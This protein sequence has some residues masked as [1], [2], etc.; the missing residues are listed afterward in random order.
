MS[1]KLLDNGTIFTYHDDI[2]SSPDILDVNFE[3]LKAFIKTVAPK[4]I[5]RRYTQYRTKQR[6]TLMDAEQQLATIPKGDRN[7]TL[8]ELTGQL[9]NYHQADYLL[10]HWLPIADKCIPDEIGQNQRTIESAIE[11]Y[12]DCLQYRQKKQ[13]AGDLALQAMPAIKFKGKA[14]TTRRAVYKALITRSNQEV[15]T[16]SFVATYRQIKKLTGI[17]SN[18]GI[19]KALQYLCNLQVIQR[20]S[21]NNASTSY[22]R[23]PSK[24]QWNTQVLQQLIDSIESVSS[25][26]DKAEVGQKQHISLTTD[27][28]GYY[29]YHLSDFD[30]DD[31]NYYEQCLSEPSALGRNGAAIYLYLL[32]QQESCRVSAI[33]KA[34]QLNVRTVRRNVNKLVDLQ[35]AKRD[36]Y[37]ISA[38]YDPKQVQTVLLKTGAMKT[39]RKHETRIDEERLWQAIDHVCIG[40]IKADRSHHMNIN[41][42]HYKHRIEND[43]VVIEILPAPTKKAEK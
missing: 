32:H 2:D 33:A 22:P 26:V 14:G 10:Q 1:T 13:R 25:D 5:V 24:W 11:S 36:G 39:R 28:E 20:V 41:N 15:N 23:K 30:Q 7:N 42:L 4:T 16:S 27:N 29:A 19:R 40:R 35:L 17:R 3:S 6:L 9:L 38:T 31:G 18:R 8:F 21:G 37:N 12:Q 34:L 43:E